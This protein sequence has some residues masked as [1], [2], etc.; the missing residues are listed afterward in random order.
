MLYSE[1]GEPDD[2]DYP[3]ELGG[4]VPVSLRDLLD[5]F[6]ESDG[7]GMKLMREGEWDRLC[8]WYYIVTYWVTAETHDGKWVVEGLKSY[9]EFMK[10]KIELDCSHLGR[11][12]RS[13]HPLVRIAKKKHVIA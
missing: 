2:G 1:K 13:V 7:P 3:F 11:K 5:V 10:W 4:R 9:Y 8:A 6:F 12:N